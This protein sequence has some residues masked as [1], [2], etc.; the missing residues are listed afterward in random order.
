[1]VLLPLVGKV[2]ALVP[3][4]IA[5][6]AHRIDTL[7]HFLHLPLQNASVDRH[8]LVRCA[9][10]LPGAIGDRALADPRHHVLAIDVI[11]DE[12]AIRILVGDIVEMDSVEKVRCDGGALRRNVGVVPEVHRVLV[13]DRHAD[14]ERVVAGSLVAVADCQHVREHNRMADPPVIGIF[15]M[16]GKQSVLGQAE[17]KLAKVDLLVW[18][19][20]GDLDAFLLLLEFVVM[21]VEPLG[22]NRVHRVFHDLQPVDRQ[23]HASHHPDRA[24]MHESVEARQQRPGFRAEIGEKKPA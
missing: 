17:F 9:K 6:D 13:I 18:R 16:A 20:N 21:T 8:A 22:M 19:A 12:L 24:R 3:R 10:V 15:R 14:L 1:M 4:R 11:N 7:R 5:N 2:D 23:H